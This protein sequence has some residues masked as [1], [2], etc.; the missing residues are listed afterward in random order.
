[1][2]AAL[3]IFV[4]EYLAVVAGVFMTVAVAAFV[5]IPFSLERHPG[6]APASVRAAGW[7]AS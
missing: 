1:M 4:Q 2:D 5:A 7:H 3:R 6:E